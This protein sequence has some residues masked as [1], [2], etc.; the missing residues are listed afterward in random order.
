MRKIGLRVVAVLAGSALLPS[1]AYAKGSNLQFGEREYAPGDRAVGHALVETWPGSGNEPQG[2]PYGIY[3]VR[4]TQALWYAHLPADAIPVGELRIGTLVASHGTSKTYRVTVAFDVPRI[5]GG[6]YAV[7]ICR[8]E[9]GANSGFG[10][11]VSGGIVVVR[12]PRVDISEDQRDL[13]PRSQ[14]SGPTGSVDFPWTVLGVVALVAAMMASAWHLHRAH[15][16]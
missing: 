7:W 5:R 4:G 14:S 10:D 16:E 12:R 11:L 8:A 1:E 15:P 3:L 2:G 6:R 13:S 9:C